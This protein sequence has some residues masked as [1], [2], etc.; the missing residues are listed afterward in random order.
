V[1]ATAFGDRSMPYLLSI[2]SVWCDAANLD[3]T[4]SFWQR[5][6]AHSHNGRIYLN[7]PGQG[8]EGE[9]ILGDTFGANY[10]RLREIERKY[11]PDNRF[12]FNQNLKPAS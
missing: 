9:K 6:R 10:T 8:E 1:D 2:D 7:F 3:W 12:C 5:M 4:R 11:D